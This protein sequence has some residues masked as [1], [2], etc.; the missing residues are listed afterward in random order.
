MTADVP[1]GYMFGDSLLESNGIPIG[2]AGGLKTMTFTA[3]TIEVEIQEVKTLHFKTELNKFNW[4]SEFGR[5][6]YGRKKS[7][8]IKNWRKNRLKRQLFT[9]NE[10]KKGIKERR[11]EIITTMV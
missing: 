1:S 3:G 8:R 5:R 10:E 7:I 6:K 9:R 11:K 2:V 4:W